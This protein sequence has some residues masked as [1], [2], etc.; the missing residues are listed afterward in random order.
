MQIQHSV[1][2]T[3]LFLKVLSLRVNFLSFLNLFNDLPNAEDLSTNLPER[4]V[5]ADL[6]Q[7]V[8]DA[9]YP[10]AILLL[11]MQMIFWL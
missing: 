6:I 5:I 10:S 11:L 9:K 2:R 7:N 8:P 3:L 1:H 4:L